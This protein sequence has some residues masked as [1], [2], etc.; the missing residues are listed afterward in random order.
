MITP[1]HGERQK[2]GEMARGRSILTQLHRAA[3]AAAREV[4]RASRE[5]ERERQA[6]IREA[7]RTR[8]AEE[9]AAQQLLKAQ[10]VSE[11]R[12][13]KAA[14]TEQKRLEKAAKEAHLAA[15]EAEAA[16]KNA[17]LAQIY[18]EIDGLLAAT[19][20]VD[21]Y[22]DL[23]SLK[24]TAEHPPFDRVDLEARVPRPEP[25]SN[26]PEPNYVPPVPPTGLFAFLR[27][28]K[29]ALAVNEAEAKHRSASAKWNTEVAH[30][31]AANKE[32]V[33]IH[34]RSETARLCDLEK[35]QARY[36][37]A[38][39]QREAEVAKQN[40]EVDSLIANLGYGTVEAIQEYTSIVLANSIYPEHFPV[41][42]EFEFDPESAELRLRALVPAPDTIP[43]TKEFKYNKSQDAIVESSLSQ[44]ACKDRYAGAVHEVALRTLHE[45]F[46]ADRRAII[47]T[48]S[49]EVGTDTIDPATGQQKFIPFVAT[50]AE[51][52]KFLQVNLSN[53]VPTATLEHLGA[54]VSK[55]PFGLVAAKGS[56]VRRS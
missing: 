51:R 5:V 55:N 21:D 3:K 53:I 26:P 47:Q 12:Q 45:V 43:S 52:E 49:L 28:K 22:V 23:E 44:K 19:I 8:K 36:A 4:E 46:E 33:E 50:G 20:D 56:G 6:A 18:D 25:L 1:S 29:H 30:R 16:E 39:A 9:R 42:H 37:E 40:G 35:E 15:M 13:V 27:K 38:C 2:A 17:E 48:I 7:E 32:S 14:A 24:Q 41:E 11:K 10:A 31:E 54:S 34:Q